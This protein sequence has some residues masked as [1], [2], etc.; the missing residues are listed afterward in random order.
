MTELQSD[1][2]TSVARVATCLAQNLPTFYD[3]LAKLNRKAAQLNCEPLL[4]VE[5]E[6]YT[7]KR[8]SAI[9]GP[10]E[11]TYV[12][13]EISGGLPRLAGG[14]TYLGTIERTETGATLVHGDDARVLALRDCGPICDH[15]KIERFR[16]KTIIAVS[17]TGEIVRIGSSCVKDFFGFHGDPARCLQ[18][19]QE[20]RDWSEELSD[21]TRS[22]HSLR[23]ESFLP[24]V[25]ALVRAHG[26]SP[27]SETYSTKSQIGYVLKPFSEDDER[28][29]REIRKSIT[30]AD[31]ET[32]KAMIE[33]AK[34]LD[35][36]NAYL[37]NLR[38]I[39]ETGVVVERQ[40]GLVA[41][42]PTA[43]YKAQSKIEQRADDAAGV[44]VEGKYVVEGTVLST[45]WQDNA[46]GGALKMIVRVEQTDGVVKIWGSVPS[47]IDPK[48][49]DTVRFSATVERSDDDD[50]GFFKRPTMAE[51]VG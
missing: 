32:A 36:D 26:F 35:A 41:S 10:L 20:A 4:A 51:I 6:R 17:A 27:S 38:E 43:Y 25:I 45:K 22:V 1:A 15:C 11:V 37:S 39:A 14:W 3:R 44:V 19:E 33:W 40:F 28:F 18:W 5:I 8:E 42:L 29:S 9:S 13:L 31:R 47:S 48:I 21:A 7:E 24:I 30:D 46:Y 2:T 16:R 23:L 34:T 12:T 50:F 49:G